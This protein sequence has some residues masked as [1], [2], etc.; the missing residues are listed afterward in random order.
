MVANRATA[1]GSPGQLARDMAKNMEE[2]AANG[3]WSGVEQVVVRLRSVVLEVPE[4]ERR[5][6]MEFVNYCLERVRTKALSSRGEVTGK[7]SEIRRGRDAAR[8]Y[9]GSLAP[10]PEPENELR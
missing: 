1:E 9:G 8:A 7:L 4:Q 10:R 5:E 2:L 6:V 3:Q